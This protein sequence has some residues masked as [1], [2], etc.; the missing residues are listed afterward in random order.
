MLA[1]HLTAERAVLVSAKGRTASEWKLVQVGRDNHLLDC[2]VGSAAAASML[3]AALDG[4]A[5][6]GAQASRQR[7][8][9]SDIRKGGRK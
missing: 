1:E 6:S 9:L 8:K 2:L 7:V 5:G 4:D 3:G